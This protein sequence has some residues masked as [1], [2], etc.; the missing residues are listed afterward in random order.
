M[1]I[2]IQTKTTTIYDYSIFGGIDS[3]GSIK[4]VFGAD[5]LSNALL[6][7]ISSFRGDQIRNPL[8][9][10]IFANLITKPM[11]QIHVQTATRQALT[12]LNNEFDIT[13]KDVKLTLEPNYEKRYWTV[14]LSA[15][16]PDINDSVNIST[17]IKSQS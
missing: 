7:W 9:G 6:L 5:A 17:K 12:A 3:A 13:L 15:W 4:Q 16:S 1:S 2:D 8:N 14:T 10:G 11:N